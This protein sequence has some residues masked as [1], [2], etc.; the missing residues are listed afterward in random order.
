[1]TVKVVFI[2]GQGIHIAKSEKFGNVF[3]SHSRQLNAASRKSLEIQASSVA[4]QRTL[5]NRQ[6][7]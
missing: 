4:K 2:L 1:M 7:V 5:A 6:F 3:N